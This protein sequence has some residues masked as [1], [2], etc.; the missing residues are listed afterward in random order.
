MFKRSS[1]LLLSLIFIACSSDNNNDTGTGGGG[2]AGTVVDQG[3]A[4]EDM[5]AAVDMGE[6][7][8][9]A[10]PAPDMGEAAP[11]LGPPDMGEPDMG[12]MDAG[13]APDLGPMP[14]MGMGAGFC[15]TPE[16]TDALNMTDI[17][18]DTDT[19]G[20]DCLLD[21][22]RVQ[23]TVDCLMMAAGIDQPCAQCFADRVDCTIS[24]CVGEC[25]ADSNAPE[26]VQCQ[27]DN[28]CTSNFDTCSGI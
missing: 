8:M 14:D 13:P 21:P 18:A 5:G 12:E 19:C 2:D 7:Q 11:D 23:C 15:T 9:D 16:N 1:P 28:N 10:G 6:A 25:I 27:I 26:C 4:M 22:N 24:N 3:A 20:R 17:A